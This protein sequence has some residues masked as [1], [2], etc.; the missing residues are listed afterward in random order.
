MDLI[1]KYLNP[2][3][4]FCEIF[5]KYVDRWNKFYKL[6]SEGERRY[7]LQII[8]QLKEADNCLRVAAA[9][10]QSMFYDDTEDAKSIKESVLTLLNLLQD[11]QRVDPVTYN[12]IKSA[13]RKRGGC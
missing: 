7:I 1:L 9:L 6:S 5:G 8:S 10:L 3:G 11:E 4:R 13:T 2:K 12:N